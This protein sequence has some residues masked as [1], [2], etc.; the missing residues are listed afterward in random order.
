MFPS[1]PLVLTLP[2]TQYS[3][4]D[5]DRRSRPSGKFFDCQLVL[6]NSTRWLF[7]I[8]CQGRVCAVFSN[9]LELSHLENFPYTGKVLTCIGKHFSCCAGMV[10]A[11]SI[12]SEG[13][14]AARFE[15]LNLRVCVLVDFRQSRRLAVRDSNVTALSLSSSMSV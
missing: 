6:R 15:T 12:Y 1:N 5:S 13:L 7:P 2:I 11:C 3:R 10:A 4:V 14:G 8:N 9:P